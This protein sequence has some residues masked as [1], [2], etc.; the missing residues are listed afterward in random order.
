MLSNK[1]H[2]NSHDANIVNLRHDYHTTRK[3]SKHLNSQI[4]DLVNHKD[5]HKF[6]DYLKLL[7]EGHNTSSN[8]HDIPVDKLYI[9]FQLQDLHSSINPSSLSPGHNT[10]GE[11]ISSL[12]ETKATHNYLDTTISPAEIESMTKL[13][14][15]KK[16]PGP[17]KI[18]NEM[19]KTGIQYFITALCKLF[20][21]L[22]LKSGFFPSTWC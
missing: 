10:L 13:L 22:I 12:E 17:D 18:R 11:N 16:V 9:H 2:R 15:S 8:N 19:L 1:K 7:K 4:E 14:R 3:K 6:W 20:N 5:S 21:N